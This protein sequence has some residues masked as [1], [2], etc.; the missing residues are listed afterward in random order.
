M[1]N[2]NPSIDPSLERNL[3]GTLQF[4]FSKMMQTTEGM[5]P[6]QVVAYNRTE[7]RAQVQPLIT[8]VNTNGE[9]ISRAQIASVP[10][11]ILGGGGYMLNFNL[12]PG[13][14]GWILAND[15]DISG[16]LQTYAQSSPN[17]VRKNSFADAVFVPDIMRDYTI[18]GEDNDNAVLQ[19]TDGTVKI[20]LGTNKIKLSATV[21]E[22]DGDVICDN[23]LT[24][25]GELIINDG[26]SSTGGGTNNA[27]FTGNLRVVG[28]ITASG[29][30]TP[31]IP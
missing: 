19:S 27:T 20:S 2:S 4:A 25:N 5:L 23:T 12:N 16:F 7:N 15:R 1:S 31:D 13:D 3:T 6:A 30:I 8:L 9:Q 10:V 26:L 29:T 11:L 24:V 18:A 17:T 21:I 14:L 22:L 28:N